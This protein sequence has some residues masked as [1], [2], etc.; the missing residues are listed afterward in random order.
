MIPVEEMWPVYRQQ[1]GEKINVLTNLV[2][3]HNI[4]KKEI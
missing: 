2:Y 4:D 1:S 3:S